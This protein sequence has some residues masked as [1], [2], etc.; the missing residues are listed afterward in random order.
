MSKKQSYS[1]SPI[2]EA[3][4]EFRFTGDWDNTIPGMF[5]SKIRNKYPIKNTK[6]FI[7]VDFRTPEKKKSNFQPR[8]NQIMQFTNSKKNSMVSVGNNTLSVHIIKDYTTWSDYQPIIIDNFNKYLEIA[9]PKEIQRIGLRYINR[10]NIPK[11]EIK[12]EDYFS[13]YINIPKG[14]NQDISSFLANTRLFYNEDIDRMQINLFSIEK[15]EQESDKFV[16]FILDIDY[17]MAQPNAINNKGVLE[18][19][20]LANNNIYNAFEKVLTPKSKELIK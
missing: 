7:E 8:K 18:W 3:V 17:W 9:K 20:N 11:K 19:L 2:L 16:S 12:I 6:D 5:F 10:L 1:N 4:C 15:K 14:V 13:Y